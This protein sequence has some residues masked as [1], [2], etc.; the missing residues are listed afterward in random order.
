MSNIC[1]RS[2]RWLCRCEAYRP[3]TARLGSARL[4][5]AS[6][7]ISFRSHCRSVLW[8]GTP[9]KEAG[10]HSQSSA[11]YNPPPRGR[12][13]YIT[14]WDSF[15]SDFLCRETGTLAAGG[16]ACA[17]E[18]GLDRVWTGLD[19]FIPAL[20]M[21]PHVWTLTAVQP[22]QLLNLLSHVISVWQQDCHI[23]ND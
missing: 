23:S 3:G 5:P 6:I 4:G 11:G 10:Q 12:N 13:S 22:H 18:S 15:L 8:C 9:V 7:M 14:L 16:E 17:G 21:S 2:Q 1:C 19:C 20:I